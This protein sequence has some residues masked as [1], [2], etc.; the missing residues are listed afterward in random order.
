MESNL[1]KQTD[2]RMPNK[3]KIIEHWADN[4]INEYGKYWLDLHYDDPSSEIYL[5]FACGSNVLTD[6]AHIIPKMLGGF[7]TSNNLHLLCKECHIESESLE[8]REAYF[9]IF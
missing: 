3:L 1:S 5:C 9:E 7:N 6:L 8:N 4:L 2:K